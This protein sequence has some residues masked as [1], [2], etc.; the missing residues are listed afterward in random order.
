MN[1]HFVET[2]QNK[3]FPCEWSIL[4]HYEITQK[5]WIVSMDLKEFYFQNIEEDGYHYRFNDSIENVNNAYNI[6]SGYTEVEDYEFEVYDN[7]V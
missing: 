3:R 4:M 7:K 1:F 5:N 6:F 2:S